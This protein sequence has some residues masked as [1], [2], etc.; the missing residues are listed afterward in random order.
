MRSAPVA[1][2]VLQEAALNGEADFLVVFKDQPGQALAQQRFS[3]ARRTGAGGL[4][5]APGQ[6]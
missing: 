6:R 5:N 2:K 1:A 4:S 3:S